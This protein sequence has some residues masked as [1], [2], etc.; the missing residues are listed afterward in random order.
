MKSKIKSH[1]EEVTDFYNKNFP[2]V[3]SNHTS[4]VEISL[5]SSLKE[6]DNYHPQVFLKEC[7]YIQEKLI[8]YINDNLSDF[9]SSDKSDEEL[10]RIS[11]S[12]VS[13]NIE[14]YF[15][16][17]ECPQNKRFK[18]IFIYIALKYTE[19]CLQSIKIQKT[20]Q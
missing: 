17:G 14:Y 11:W 19:V 9:S 12:C 3:E 8:R 18:T 7:K 5:N 2:K 15:L 4:L 13:K 1:G 20:I 10:I 16:N 6:D